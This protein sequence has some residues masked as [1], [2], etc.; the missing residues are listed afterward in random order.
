MIQ[1][2]NYSQR[3]RME[4]Q[5]CTFSPVKARRTNNMIGGKMRH[6]GEPQVTIPRFNYQVM[7]VSLH[8]DIWRD[9]FMSEIW[10][11]PCARNLGLTA[12]AP[13]RTSP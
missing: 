2:M 13:R 10:P 11:D 6:L 5:R 3:G 7:E 9:E 1:L 4:E 12:T 8:Q